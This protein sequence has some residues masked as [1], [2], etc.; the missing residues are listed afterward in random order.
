MTAATA[1]ALVS[2][3][4]AATVAVVVPLVAF[5]LA[6]RQDAIRWLRERR[7]DVYVALLMQ[8]TAL[9][10][11]LELNLSN[12]VTRQH[13]T[14][15]FEDLQLSSVEEARLAAR[16]K[17]FGSKTVNRLFEDLREEALQAPLYRQDPE[18]IGRDGWLRLYQM[19]GYLEAAI[20][21]ELGADRIALG[22]ERPTNG[23]ALEGEESHGLI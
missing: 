6:L 11:R 15:L 2:A 23:I 20:R 8:A 12:D 4:L 9:R 21:R 19:S 16:T 1:V 14:R 10:A 13:L 17:I 3:G 18:G 7:A 5:R 22:T